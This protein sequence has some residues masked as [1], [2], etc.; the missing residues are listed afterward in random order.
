MEIGKGKFY[1][2]TVKEAEEKGF[3]RAYR[4]KGKQAN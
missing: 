3:R 1:C 2:A 4:W